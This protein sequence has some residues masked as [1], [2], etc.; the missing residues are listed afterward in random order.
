[1]LDSSPGETRLGAVTKFHVNQSNAFL[2]SDASEIGVNRSTYVGGVVSLPGIERDKPSPFHYLINSVKAKVAINPYW[3]DLASAGQGWS[4][5]PNPY[6]IALIA[7]REQTDTFLLQLREASNEVIP[8]SGTEI[9]IAIFQCE[10]IIDVGFPIRNQGTMPSDNDYRGVPYSVSGADYDRTQTGLTD[11]FPFYFNNPFDK[12]APVINKNVRI[13]NSAT[14]L[15][16]LMQR[17]NSDVDAYSKKLL[18]PTE[19]IT[20]LL[21]PP[22]MYIPSSTAV[23]APGNW[24]GLEIDVTGMYSRELEDLIPYV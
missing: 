10:R 6:M 1:M 4:R 18:A 14:E 22:L 2:Q 23:D 24:F 13:V 11:N 5:V 12:F 19:L 16:L 20:Y 15:N 21:V 7:T 3:T 8:D 17:I 9:K